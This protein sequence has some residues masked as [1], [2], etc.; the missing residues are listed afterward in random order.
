MNDLSLRPGRWT[1]Y[2]NTQVTTLP[3]DHKSLSQQPTFPPDPNRPVQ[4]VTPQCFEKAF[5]QGIKS[6]HSVVKLKTFATLSQ[7]C[8]TR[9][10]KAIRNTV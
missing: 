3:S 6:L 8:T 5:L 2:T 7:L 1:N 10:M 9:K 4:Y